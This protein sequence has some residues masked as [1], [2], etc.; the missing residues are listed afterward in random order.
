M[1]HMKNFNKTFKKAKTRKIRKMSIKINL[2]NRKNGI[3]AIKYV[4]YIQNTNF[5]IKP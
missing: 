1:M 4:I 2:L 5:K 3:L